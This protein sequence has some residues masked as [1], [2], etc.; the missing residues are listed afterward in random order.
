VPI[1]D[2]FRI[3]R[4]QPGSAVDIK[5]LLEAL[6]HQL[7]DARAPV[8]ESLRQLLALIILDSL[9]T[10]SENSAFSNSNAIEAVLYRMFACAHNL[11]VQQ[12]GCSI[13]AAFFFVLKPQDDLIPRGLE[14]SLRALI[15]ALKTFHDDCVIQTQVCK[16]L[17]K[18]TVE[19]S[20]L[21]LVCSLGGLQEIG[22][23][24][25][26]LGQMLKY[27]IDSIA[28]I[29]F[30]LPTVMSLVAAVRLRFGSN[31]TLPTPSFHC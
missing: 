5:I 13:L 18:L 30:A 4:D 28:V 2:L 8:E 31:M 9:S 19:K 22:E 14:Q 12:L 26:V 17:S 24:I 15:R 27:I 25:H 29:E 10:N 7:D 3:L 20:P 1:Q 21:E 23:A 6:L 16:A 11:K